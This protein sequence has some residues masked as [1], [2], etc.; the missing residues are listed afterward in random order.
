LLRGDPSPRVRSAATRALV[1]IADSASIESLIASLADNDRQ[2]RFWAWKG[3]VAFGAEESIPRLFKH[4]RQ[5]ASTKMTS[6]EN[7]AGD[8]VWL[9][10]EIN[11]RIPDFGGA[12][13]PFLVAGFED[14]D[15]WLLG[16]LLLIIK[17]VGPKA[18]DTIPALTAYMERTA[19]ETHKLWAIAALEE[20]GDLHPLVMP[21]LQKATTDPS[22]KVAN[23]AQKTIKAIQKDQ[24]EKDKG[25]GRPSAAKTRPQKP[26]PSPQEEEPVNEKELT[27]D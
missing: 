18:Q 22:R 19:N 2:V 3:I 24:K 25:K 26:S 16:S 14:D 12:A 11:H 10:L 17:D 23:Q 27:T 1:A 7:E 20:M 21:T 5:D 13:T 8:Q 15:E 9:R 6:Y 4:L